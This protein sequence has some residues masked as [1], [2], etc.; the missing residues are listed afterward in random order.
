MSDLPGPLLHNYLQ[1]LLSRLITLLKANITHIEPEICLNHM[2]L[3]VLKELVL[4]VLEGHLL[5]YGRLLGLKPVEGLVG[6][7][8]LPGQALF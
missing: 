1:P 3:H 5:G 7:E 4:D 8:L 2:C 6:E